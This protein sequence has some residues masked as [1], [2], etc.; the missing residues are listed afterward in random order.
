MKQNGKKDMVDNQSPLRQSKEDPIT[1][2]PALNVSQPLTD[3]SPQDVTADVLEKGKSVEAQS[4]ASTS[5]GTTNDSTTPQPP[6]QIHG[7]TEVNSVGTK[8]SNLPLVASAALESDS[9]SLQ[10]IGPKVFEGMHALIRDCQ[11]QNDT[12]SLLSLPH[13]AISDQ[14]I[15][16]ALVE[17]PPFTMARVPAPSR[18][19]DVARPPTI[20][21]SFALLQQESE[22]DSQSEALDSDLALT[23]QHDSLALFQSPKSASTPSKQKK[24]KRKCLVQ[25]SPK[26]GGENPLNARG[27]HHN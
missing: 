27:S 10:I 24:K 2:H 3:G 16:K 1:D 13:H 25:N 8:T 15:K 22:S 21:N 5:S 18:N 11:L 17:E 9:I 26:S 20:S 7:S 14:Q 12:S 4:D 23:S 19:L 6:S